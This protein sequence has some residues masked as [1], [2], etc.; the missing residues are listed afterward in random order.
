MQN[1]NRHGHRSFPDT[2]WTA[3]AV[4]LPLRY[5]PSFAGIQR[6]SRHLRRGASGR[7]GLDGSFDGEC[8]SRPV[9]TGAMTMQWLGSPPAFTGS[10]ASRQSARSDPEREADGGARQPHLARPVFT[11]RGD[12]G[13]RDPRSRPTP[14]RPTSGALSTHKRARRT[15]RHFGSYSFHVTKSEDFSNERD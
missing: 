10:R 3:G 13:R 6:G 11:T 7:V 8:P 4:R 9:V 1:S 14:T 5:G 15:S 2:N 12:G